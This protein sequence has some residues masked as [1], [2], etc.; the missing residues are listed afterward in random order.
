MKLYLRQ[1]FVVLLIIAIL[2][3]LFI[4]TQAVNLDQHSHVIDIVRQLEHSDTML[5]ENVLKSRY[6]TLNNYDTLVKI[7][8]RMNDLLFILKKGR[9]SIYKKGQHNIDAEIDSAQKMMREKEALLEKFKS[10]NALLRN[11]I[12]YFPLATAKFV[13]GIP[14]M[15]NIKKGRAAVLAA[16]MNDVLIDTLVYTLVANQSD[17]KQHIISHIEAVEASKDQYPASQRELI[18]TIAGHA[19]KILELKPEVD[20]LL[21]SLITLP[22]AKRYDA[23]YKSYQAY[24]EELLHEANLYRL[25][26]YLF[27]ILLIAYVVFILLRLKR[28]TVALT[29]AVDEL[30]Q[31]KAVLYESQEK[32]RTFNQE[33]EKRVHE[34]TIE[35][36]STNAQ[37]VY[38]L[39]DL[40]HKNEE[41][42]MFVYSVSHDLRS[43]LVNLQG[44]SKELISVSSDIRKLIEEDA[45]SA[46][47][48]RRG[49]SLI[50][51]DMM[52]SIRFIQAAVTRLSIIMD[53]LLRLSRVGRVEYKF[54]QIDPTPIIKRI[55]ESMQSITNERNATIAVRE[56]PTVWADP[57][58]L[59]Q[60]FANIIGNA[61]NYLD[62]KRPGKIE[63]GC[64]PES[65]KILNEA[66]HVLYVKDNG[67]GIGEQAKSKLFR[68]FQRLHPNA[69]EGE[70]VGLAIVR[71]IVERHGGRITVES[72]EG[73][74]TTFFVALPLQM[75]KDIPIFNNIS[76]PA[77]F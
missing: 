8:D 56:L 59:E 26:L 5:N 40:T 49:I 41:N 14:F 47:I 45:C 42:E 20:S 61:L 32:L 23:L 57:S 54:Q 65:E 58:A 33:L 2:T 24:H 73:M 10:Q 27:C 17:S 71:R 50:D 31:Q 38:Y 19:K 64:C 44:F 67:L 1:G 36:D 74:G 77:V 63:I 62:P 35:L 69:A 9:Y 30:Q 4:K 18:Q 16:D 39:D 22:S 70:G 52:G 29:H 37:L 60:I 34:R 12:N 13:E 21:K 72:T 43:P 25:G 55:V 15:E 66:M 3:G 7:T 48:K 11:S 46:D 76:E 53:S 51:Q 68:I 6:G 28:S 75:I